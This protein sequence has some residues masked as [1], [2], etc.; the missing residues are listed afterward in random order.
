MKVLRI[1]LADDHVLFR[2]GLAQL[3]NSQPDFEV[4][5]EAT[6]GNEAIAK[7]KALKPDVILMDINMPNCS[8]FEATR[9]I[10][11]QHPDVQVVVLTVS[12]DENDLKAAVQSGANGYLL[13][14][15]SPEI[16]FQ[17]LRGLVSGQVPISRA[18]MG[19]LFHQLAQKDQSSPRPVANSALSDRESQVL[20]LVVNGFSNQEIADE[21]G[22]AR[23]TAKNHLHNILGKLGVKNRAQATAYAIQHG[24]V[25]L[26]DPSSDSPSI[27][28]IDY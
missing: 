24:L 13:K 25:S 27:D 7:I 11:T 1:L 12:E 17:Q 26:K 21:L 4:I 15:L 3:L 28:H 14:D 22:I 20:A 8:G 16:L 5:G 19:K 23:N 10:K 6:D 18:M 9:R 2:K